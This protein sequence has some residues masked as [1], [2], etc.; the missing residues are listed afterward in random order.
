MNIYSKSKKK[1][2]YI[3]IQRLFKVKIRDFGMFD[4][5]TFQKKKE[6]RN[7]ESL[8]LVFNIQTNVQV[9]RL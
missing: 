9:Y 4:T 2:T 1:N 8:K 7:E 3:Y 6:I 5:Y